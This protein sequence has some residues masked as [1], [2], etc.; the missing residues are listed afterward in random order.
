MTIYLGGVELKCVRCAL[1][2]VPAEVK[3]K[4]HFYNTPATPDL[5]DAACAL[6][7]IKQKVKPGDFVV[8]ILLVLLVIIFEYLAIVSTLSCPPHAPLPGDQAGH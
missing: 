1:Q 7:I 5:N 2:Q 3:P 6:A 4:L 8:C